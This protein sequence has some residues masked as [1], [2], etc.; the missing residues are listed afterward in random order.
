MVYL[1][2]VGGSSQLTRE[3]N[4]IGDAILSFSQAKALAT[5]D[6]LSASPASKTRPSG[7]FSKLPSLAIK[8]DQPDLRPSRQHG[9]R[10]EH[11]LTQRRGQPI[12]WRDWPP[13][14][15]RRCPGFLF[16]WSA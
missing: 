15:V 9:V 8:S 3:I 14:A 6:P 12:R 11:G 4:D 10:V 5:D 13:S 2:R 7:A 1:S 16:H